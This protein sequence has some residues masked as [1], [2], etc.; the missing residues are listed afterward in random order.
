M[1]ESAAIPVLKLV[2]VGNGTR[3]IG[4][5]KTCLVLGYQGYSYSELSYEPHVFDETMVSVKIDGEE[6]HILL[7]DTGGGVSL[8][9]FR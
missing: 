8:H 2:L 7:H 4:V 3:G 5:G 1:T 6:H 9:D